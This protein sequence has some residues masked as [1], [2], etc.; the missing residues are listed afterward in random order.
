MTPEEERSYGIGYKQALIGMLG[1]VLRGLGYDGLDEA[2]QV[3]FELAARLKEREEAIV[4]LRRV[5]GE[6]GDNDWEDN[7]HLADVIEKH[8]GAYVIE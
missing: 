3:R 5:C 6:V 7:L 1:S 2:E 4:Q 8:L